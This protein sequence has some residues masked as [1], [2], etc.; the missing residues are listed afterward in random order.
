VP[1]YGPFPQSSVGAETVMLLSVCVVLAASEQMIGATTVHVPAIAGAAPNI[2]APTAIIAAM[3]ER[4]TPLLS[5]IS[6]DHVAR[7]T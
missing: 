2:G 7:R 3:I 6:G 4:L 5:E 1:L